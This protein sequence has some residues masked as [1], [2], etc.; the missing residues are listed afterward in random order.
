MMGPNY[1]GSEIHLRGRIMTD[2]ISGRPSKNPY[3]VLS[4]LEKST[5]GRVR[6]SRTHARNPSNVDVISV[7]NMQ[8]KSADAKDEVSQIATELTNTNADASKSAQRVKQLW[9][10]YKDEDLQKQFT[11]ILK[12]FTPSEAVTID[13]NLGWAQNANKN[14]EVGKLLIAFR[15]AAEKRS[16][17]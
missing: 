10:H 8:K 9:K 2:R 4:N 13:N 1:A 7:R 5:E 12:G 3:E 6:L 11:D 16:Q 17:E 14:E 15:S